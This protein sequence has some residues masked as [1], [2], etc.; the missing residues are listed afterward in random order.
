MCIAVKIVTVGRVLTLTIAHQ[1]MQLAS[2]QVSRLLEKKVRHQYKYLQTAKLKAR[3]IVCLQGLLIS[4]AI[5]S[6]TIL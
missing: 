5:A 1:K 2:I 6:C 4:V 3:P